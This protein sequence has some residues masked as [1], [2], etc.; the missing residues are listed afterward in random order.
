MKEPTRLI[1]GEGSALERLFLGH[2]AQEEPSDA[3]TALLLSPLFS[4]VNLQGPPHVGSP[5][6]VHAPPPHGPAVQGTGHA[7]AGS[8]AGA[9]SLHPGAAFMTAHGVAWLGAGVL[10]LGLAALGVGQLT[11][12][13]DSGE[14]HATETSVPAATPQ[15]GEPP[16]AFEPQRRPDPPHVL[17]LQDALQPQDALQLQDSS[18]GRRSPESESVGMS[19]VQPKGLPPGAVHTTQAERANTSAPPGLNT[20]SSART[21]GTQ[22][23]TLQADVAIKSSASAPVSHLRD[24]LELLEQV[25]T[26]LRG[27]Q[28]DT[29]LR[30]LARYDARFPDGALR[31]EALVLRMEALNASGQDAAAS[32]LRAK[33]LVDHPDSP[34]QTRV[35]NT[36]PK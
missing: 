6:P 4:P 17:K 1:H 14:R 18:Q 26:A 15:P 10:V 12:R 5:P 29:A 32:Q 31:E 16:Q 21:G 8:G 28:T 11:Q 9:A 33:F 20:S 35:E 7:S 34:H 30:R 2:A 23:E 25:R 36:V 22:A 24:E 3:T 13:G 19:L 27:G